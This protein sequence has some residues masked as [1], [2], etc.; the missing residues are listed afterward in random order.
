MLAS[1]AGGLLKSWQTCRQSISSAGFVVN[2]EDADRPPS[3][4]GISE[5]AP[6]HHD[7]TPF[8][9]GV[10]LS[11][12]KISEFTSLSPVRD[13]NCGICA[14]LQPFRSSC[15]SG[16]SLAHSRVS[17]LTNTR[18]PGQRG[19][20]RTCPWCL[21]WSVLTRDHEFS[22]READGHWCA[23]GLLRVRCVVN[24]PPHMCLM[25]SLSRSSVLR[26]IVTVIVT[27]PL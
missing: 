10:L 15:S 26:T 23:G 4:S 3:D 24:P 7:I 6:G 21:L 25:V 5:S 14:N 18:W 9:T 8:G 16:C 13:L 19:H 11:R 1:V 2:T 17:L 22:L 20:C 12:L 27:S